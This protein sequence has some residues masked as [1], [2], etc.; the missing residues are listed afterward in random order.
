MI[1]K[2]IVNTA[3]FIILLIIDNIHIHKNHRQVAGLL[4]DDDRVSGG[5]SASDL[6]KKRINYVFS[7][8]SVE[9]H[10][11][12]DTISKKGHIF[13]KMLEQIP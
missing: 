4:T 12:G 6:Q 7:C 1:Q 8:I 5:I 11:F 3:H 9:T 2:C 13:N 10:F